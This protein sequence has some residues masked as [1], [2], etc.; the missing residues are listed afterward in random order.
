MFA[1]NAVSSGKNSDKVHFLKKG[2]WEPTAISSDPTFRS[3]HINALYSPVGMYSWVQACRDWLEA[4]KD[5]LKLK[6]FINTVLGEPWEERGERPTTRQ[7]MQNRISYLKGTVPPEV[8]FLTAACDVHKGRIDVEILGWGLDQVSYSINWLSIEG[9]TL[10]FDGDAWS[11]LEK[12]IM[13]GVGGMKISLTLI[14]SGYLTEQ[15]YRFSA[16]F[17]TSVYPLKGID[18]Y[19]YKQAYRLVEVDGYGE[20]RCLQV[21]VDYYKDRLAAWLKKKV[22]EDGGLPWGTCLYPADYKDAYFKQYT[23]EQKLE[24]VNNKGEVLGY[25][26]VKRNANAANHAWDCRVYNLAAF[27]FF[28]DLVREHHGIQFTIEQFYKFIN[29][30]KKPNVE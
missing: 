3:Y 26:W 4:S 28:V 11:Q 25:K 10:S 29:P 1:L 9:D 13:N 8:L 22:M 12:V 30:D 5:V 2:K 24:E 17:G 20:L 15:V 23:N 6:T 27:D 21:V 16:R 14:D 19:N 7:I 18:R